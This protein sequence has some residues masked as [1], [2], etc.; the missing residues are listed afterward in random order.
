MLKAP[1]ST[2]A[3][4]IGVIKRTIS[5]SSPLAGKRNFRK[6]L[7][8]NKRGTRIF[9]QQQAANPDPELPIDKRGVRDTGYKL[10]GK[11]VEFAEMIPQLVVPDLTGCQL[12]PY[13]SYK[14]PEVV[15]SE[16]TSQDL[17]NAVYSQKIVAD[18]KAGK[19]SDDGAPLES[20]AEE[21]QTVDEA[22]AKARRTG[23]DIF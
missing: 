20:S 22:W 8:Y 13:V 5:T 17:F 18:F 15:Q 6:F 19:L 14:T 23:S 2:V 1:P 9:K 7:L 4:A 3:A 10:N 16:F 11:Y 12:K 21:R